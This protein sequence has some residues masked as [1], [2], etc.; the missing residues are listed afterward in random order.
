MGY[1]TV[2]LVFRYY[3]MCTNEHQITV[4]VVLGEY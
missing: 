3:V 1:I 2:W 4:L